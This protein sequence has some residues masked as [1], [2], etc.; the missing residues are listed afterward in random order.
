M[1]VHGAVR[2][3]ARWFGMPVVARLVGFSLRLQ[4]R[5]GMVSARPHPEW[6][7]YYQ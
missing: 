7:I 1:F 3:I 2:A 6:Q 4:G 5:G